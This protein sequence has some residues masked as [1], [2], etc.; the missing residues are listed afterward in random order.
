MADENQGNVI[1]KGG[2]EL[3]VQ[4]ET[5]HCE[6][7]KVRLL[8]LGKMP[9]FFRGLDDDIFLIQ[10]VTGK[11]KTF[12]E[13]LNFESGMEIVEKAHEVNFPNA[14]RWSERRAKRLA[15]LIPM[16]EKGMKIQRQL[17]T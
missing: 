14:L 6:T 15:P 12:A 11:T 17:M 5:G 16:A 10:L 8:P 13:S 7:V 9:D 4:L 1:A 3:E 2:Q